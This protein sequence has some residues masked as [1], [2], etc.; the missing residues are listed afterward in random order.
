MSSSTNASA[1]GDSQRPVHRFV[2]PELSL[3]TGGVLHEAPVTYRT[4]GE[5]NAAGDNAVVVCHALTGDVH[6]NDWWGDLLGPGRALDPEKY[7]IVCAN[8]LGS[9]YGSASPLTRNPETGECY[10]PAFPQVTIR[11]TVSAHRALLDHLGV[12]QV[13][14]AIG[15]SMGAM[16]VLEWAFYGS[17]VRAIV[18]IAVGGRHSAWCIG[19]SEAQRQC[20]F[21]DPK[22]RGGAYPP[23]DPPRTGLAA[24]RMNAMVSYRSPRSFAQRFSRNRMNDGTDRYQVESYLQYHGQKLTSRFDANCYVHLTRQMDTHDVSRGRGRYQ[25]VLER[26]TQPA[27]VV[28]IDSDVLYPPEEQEELARYLPHATLATLSSPHGHDAFLIEVEKLNDLV[29]SWQ[30]TLAGTDRPAPTPATTR[31]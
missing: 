16:Q 13:A 11:D 17:F 3:E 29:R 31:Q 8:V 20:I 1:A 12:R 14:F 24:A 28:A 30:K 22:W 21:A 4:W 25:A 2:V 15:G 19:W 5:L 7:F 27:L 23:D 26:I 9:P 10:G 18:P 6:V